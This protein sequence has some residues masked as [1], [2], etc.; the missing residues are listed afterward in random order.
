[1]LTVDLCDIVLI[2]FGIVEYTISHVSM[3]GVHGCGQQQ[4]TADRAP[5]PQ[6]GSTWQPRRALDHTAPIC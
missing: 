1:V 2:S 5:E 6:T 3:T 4:E